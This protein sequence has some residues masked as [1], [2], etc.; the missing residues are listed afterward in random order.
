MKSMSDAHIISFFGQNTAII[1]KSTSKFN[2]YMFIQ[3]IKKN[4]HGKW[5]K[6]TFKQ[7]R[8]IKFTLEEMIMIL[9]VLYRKTLNWKSFHTYNE[10]TTSFSFSWE[11]EEAKVLWITVADYSKVLNFAQVEIFRLLL[12]HLVEEKIIYSTSYTKKNSIKNDNH[13]KDLTQQIENYDKLHEN[14]LLLY[15]R[16]NDILK[17]ISKIKAALAGE[18]EKAIL[19]NFRANESFWIPKS[20]IHNQYLPRK[21]FNQFFL[22]DNWVLEKNNIPF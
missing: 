8:T 3:F 7:G 20:S 15:E 6:P 9:Q 16:K 13:E 5:E 1:I 2:S 21:N 18:T 17:S 10:K 11:D 19:L 12:R 14:E 4:Q 22:I